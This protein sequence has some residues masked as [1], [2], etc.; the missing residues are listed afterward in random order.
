MY[1]H[2]RFV[3]RTPWTRKSAV[4]GV[5]Q[6]YGVRSLKPAFPGSD[7]P[8]RSTVYTIAVKHGTDAAMLQDYIK[9]TDCLIGVT[10]EALGEITVAP[11]PER[12]PAR[13]VAQD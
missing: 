3:P 9:E 13:A 4:L 6:E 10:P 11:Y 7:H 12:A 5:L 8:V 2:L 1:T